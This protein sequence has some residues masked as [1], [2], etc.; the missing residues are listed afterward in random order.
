MCCIQ[1]CYVDF[2]TLLSTKYIYENN[3][4]AKISKNIAKDTGLKI[5]LDYQNNYVTMRKVLTFY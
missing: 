1:L 4:F 3:S 5:I 2:L